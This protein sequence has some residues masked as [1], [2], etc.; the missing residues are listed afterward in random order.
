VL[1]V[2]Q[3]GTAEGEIVLAVALDA[4]GNASVS[5]W[6][7]RNGVGVSVTKFDSAGAVL[8]TKELGA[9]MGGGFGLDADAQGNV[10]VSGAYLATTPYDVYVAKLDPAGTV[11]WVTPFGSLDQEAAYGLTLDTR[12]N[13]YVSGFTAGVFPGNS[14]AGP[15]DAFVAKIDPQGVLR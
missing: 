15:V 8:W 10:Y 3:F 12:G 9:A 1:G 7:N 4:Q 2:T 5:Y 14:N 13:A 6:G 11:L